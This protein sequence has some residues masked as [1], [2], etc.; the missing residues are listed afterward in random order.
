MVE[1]RQRRIK[2]GGKGRVGVRGGGGAEE[3]G[4]RKGGR[5]RGRLDGEPMCVS[6]YVFS[7]LIYLGR[8]TGRHVFV[9]FFLA[10]NWGFSSLFYFH[11]TF[12]SSFFFF[13]FLFFFFLLPFSLSYSIMSVLMFD[14]EYDGDVFFFSPGYGSLL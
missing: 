6:V 4:P 9:F 13:F 10:A 1:Q 12:F 3:G 14:H 8:L 5:R 11:P 2:P 7:A